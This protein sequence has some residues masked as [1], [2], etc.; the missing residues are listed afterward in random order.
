MR[1]RLVPLFYYQHNQNATH[2]NHIYW[3]MI[4]EY[5]QLMKLI[6]GVNN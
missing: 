2:K 5:L 4:E 6:N 1:Q 3:L